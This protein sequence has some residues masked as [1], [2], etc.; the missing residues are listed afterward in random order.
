MFPGFR[1]DFPEVSDFADTL[2]IDNVN[3]AAIILKP[4]FLPHLSHHVKCNPHYDVHNP[5]FPKSM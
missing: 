3:S 5:I 1:M 4:V 2:A